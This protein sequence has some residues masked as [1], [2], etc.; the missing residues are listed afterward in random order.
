MSQLLMDQGLRAAREGRRIDR[1]QVDQKVTASFVVEVHEDIYYDIPAGKQ[2]VI[3]HF[4]LGCETVDNF[5]G[6]YPVVCSAVTAGGSP[7][8]LH[9]E[10]HNHVGSKKEGNGHTEE[11]LYPPVV[12]KYS[13]GARSISM[14]V[15]ATDT[16]TVVKFGWAG[17]VEDEGTLS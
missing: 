2:V 13:S 3:T 1:Y 7:T 8:Q 11:D 14:A 10:I 12:V 15:K 6:A 17:W 5:A 4:F 9:H 16:D